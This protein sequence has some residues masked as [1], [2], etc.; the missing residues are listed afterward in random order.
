MSVKVGSSL[1]TEVSLQ[2]RML[3]ME[4]VAQVCRQGINRSSLY[5]LLNFAMTLKLL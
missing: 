5:F 4:A 2:F 1:I 3:I